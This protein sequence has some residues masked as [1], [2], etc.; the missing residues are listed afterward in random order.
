MSSSIEHDPEFG[1]VIPKKRAGRGCGCV[2]V[3]LVLGIIVVLL[4]LFLPFTSAVPRPAA[5]RAQCTNNLKQIGLALHE[6]VQEYDALPPAFTVDAQGR[7]LHSWRTLILP[8][9]EQEALYKTIDLSK[10]WNDPANA[11]G[12]KRLFSFFNA[13][14]RPDRRTRQP[15]WPSWRRMVASF[16]ESHDGWRRSP[17]AS[18]TR[19]QSSRPVKRVPSPGWRLWTRTSLCS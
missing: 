7:P 2:Q 13:L 17:T 6:Y 5:R 8:F 18:A 4:V 10:P 15:T 9:L 16:P 19:W 12:C 1:D 14:R 11:A 3:L